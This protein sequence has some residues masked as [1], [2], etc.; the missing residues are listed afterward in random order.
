MTTIEWLALVLGIACVVLGV[1][2]NVGTFPTGIGSVVLVG[3]LATRGRLYS[4]ALLQL[5][6]IGANVYGWINWARSRERDGAVVVEDMT[7]VSRV[8]WAAASLVVIVLW[9]GAMARF[10]DAAFPWWDGGVTVASMAA[11]LLMARRCWENWLVWIAVDLAA[12]PLYHAKNLDLV[13][14]LYVIYLALSIWGLRDWRRIAR[15][16]RVGSGPA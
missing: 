10:T 14:I 8:R 3:V 5:F 11:Q 13:A 16:A 4:D 6:Y 15:A 7:T 2:R 1:R 9:G 12:V